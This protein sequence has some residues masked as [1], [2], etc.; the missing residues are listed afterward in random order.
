MP[1]AADRICEFAIPG[2]LRDQLVDAVLRGE[3]TATSSLKVEWELENEPL[4]LGGERQTVVDSKGE[5]V[6]T[7]EILEA[8]VIRLA[9]TDLGLA[10]AEGEGF[11]S[12]AEW[13]EAH[14]HFW[15]EE[16]LPRLPTAATLSDDTLVVVERFRLVS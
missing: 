16:V 10:R 9:D 2:T 7:I 15:S 1:G 6:G 14:E 4:P 3:K 5:P 12:V 11:A 13:R 8:E